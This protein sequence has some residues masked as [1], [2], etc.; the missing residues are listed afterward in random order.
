MSL[1]EAERYYGTV[2]G[3][4]LNFRKYEET[5][6]VR[7]SDFYRFRNVTEKKSIN[8]DDV[9]SLNPIL[10]PQ[11]L[12]KVRYDLDISSLLDYKFDIGV[13]DL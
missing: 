4:I 12:K 8:R 3:L 10:I 7:I 1:V 9:L 13:N 5:Y 6:F 11:T 2:A